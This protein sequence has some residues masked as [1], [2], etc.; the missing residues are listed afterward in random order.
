MPRLLFHLLPILISCLGCQSQEN[1]N[2]TA[3]TV[4]KGATTLTLDSTDSESPDLSDPNALKIPRIEL[5]DFDKNQYISFPSVGVKLICPDS[6]TK[7]EHFFGFV[8]SNEN[9][10]VKITVLPGSAEETTANFTAEKLLEKGVKLLDKQDVTFAGGKG[11]LLKISQLTLSG[12]QEKWSL[13]F[14]DE[15]KTIMVGADYPVF[16]KEAL[17]PLLRKTVLSAKI[18][19]TAP[20]PDLSEMNF[21]ITDS[22][23][24]KLAPNEIKMHLGGMLFYTED[25][26]SP[27]KKKTDPLFFVVQSSGKAEITDLRI[28][29]QYRL[30]QTAHLIDSKVISIKEIEIDGMKGSELLAS[31]RDEDTR[32]LLMIYQVSLFDDHALFLTHGA[33]GKER[34][35]KFLPEFKKM[36]YSI[37]RKK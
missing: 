2:K 29:A 37:K 36:T 10:S 11:V 19:E 18:I 17:A 21:T 12:R 25:G 15:T 33:I 26:E 9:S 5:L 16:K 35:E 8:N 7:S 28:F 1:P 20:P 27:I 14:G 22:E 6:Y 13:V 4:I 32:D 30:L 34:S 24:L 3:K 31:A 23:K